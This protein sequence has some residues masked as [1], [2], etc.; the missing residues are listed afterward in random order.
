MIELSVSRKVLACLSKKPMTTDE[1]SKE[2]AT[3]R[4]TVANALKELKQ[5]KKICVARYEYTGVKPVAYWGIGTV[6][7][8]RPS[9]QTPE[10]IRAKKKERDRIRRQEAREEEERRKEGFKFKPRR[11]IAASWF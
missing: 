2:L 3:A 7:A 9:P 4:S 11:D 10:Q 1:L 6:D 8:P 5:N